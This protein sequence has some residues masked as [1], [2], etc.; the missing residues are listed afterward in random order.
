MSLTQLLFLFIVGI[1]VAIPAVY[2]VVR[3]A[4]AAFFNSKQQ[5]EREKSHEPR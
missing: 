2:L 1:I 4:S 5:Y 3:F